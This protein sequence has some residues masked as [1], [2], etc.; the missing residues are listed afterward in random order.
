[1]KNII[2]TIFSITDK[3]GCKKVTFFGVSLKLN[4]KRWRNRAN[5]KKL[6]ISP[7]KIVFCNYFGKSYGCNPK[8]ITEEIIRQKL[9][10]ELVWL[11]NDAKNKN[12]EFPKNV[13]VVEYDS[14]E[15]FSELATAKVWV[16]NNRLYS[17]WKQGLHKKTSQYYIQTWHGP[18]GMK[19]IEASI[20]KE[21]HSWR[22]WAKFDSKNIDCLLASNTTD[23]NILSKCFWYKG[24]IFKSGYPRNDIFFLPEN[25]KLKIKEKVY[26]NL[27]I[28]LDQ[29]MLLYLP[30]FRDDCRTTA[31]NL[32]ILRVLDTT[33]NKF[34]KSH[35]AAIKL[36]PNTPKE[37]KDLFDFKDKRIVDAISYPDIQELLIA[38]D[39]IIT[40]YSSG[41]L[42]AM[43]EYKKCFIFATDLELYKRERG[44]Y[45]PLSDTPFP[46]AENNADL[47][48]NIQNFDENHYLNK[49]QNYLQDK[50]YILDGNS[51]KRV[52][53]RIKKIIN[54]A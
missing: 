13:R 22:K 47:I 38:S 16:N 46:I 54:E 28:P 6:P 42:D 30:T 40:D 20:K 51:S 36:H 34:N 35:I 25:E 9:P 27:N 33:N 23:K 17:Y 48:K 11:V 31:F 39:I 52:V 7:N 24:E 29:Q 8:Y 4:F 18:L 15:A 19:K 49:V 50:K 26:R 53:E 3:D 21:N 12:D 5:I 14:T 2:Q 41:I 45:F 1:M 32:D 44:F 43:L 10:Y 37:V